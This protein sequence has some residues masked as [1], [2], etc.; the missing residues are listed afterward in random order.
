[1]EVETEVFDKW[2]VIVENRKV[3][4]VDHVDI[5]A[6]TEDALLPENIN[7]RFANLLAKYLLADLGQ[8]AEL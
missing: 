2:H 3:Q 7:F 5:H 8:L 4:W 6:V 1:M